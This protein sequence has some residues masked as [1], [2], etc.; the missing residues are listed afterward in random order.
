MLFEL[1]EDLLTQGIGDLGV[2][3]GVLD[4]LVTEMIGHVLDP[5][6]GFQQ[7]HRHRVAQRVHGA[8]LD[9]GRLGIVDKELLHLPLLQGPLA[10][11][12]KVGPDV[13][14]LPQ[15]AA[16]EFR[17][18]PPQRLLAA[19]PVLQ[20]PDGDPMIFEVH[21]VDGEHQG[22]A[23]AQA[24]VVDEAEEG[25]VAGRVDRR[26]EPLQLVLGEVFG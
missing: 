19:E 17:R 16:Y 2:D 11:S 13:A 23:D 5:A 6:A 25:S 12:E 20:P 24:I 18:M 14:A 15:I 9:A 21:I 10:A 1:A 8:F 26:K 4:I 22:F 3:A 7:M